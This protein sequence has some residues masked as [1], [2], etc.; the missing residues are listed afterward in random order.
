MGLSGLPATYNHETVSSEIEG[1]G[2]LDD[3]YGSVNRKN[4]FRDVA[5][6][7][8]EKLNEEQRAAFDQ[9]AS[10]IDSDEKEAKRLFFLEGAGG[11]GY[12]KNFNAFDKKNFFR[13]NIS[14]QHLN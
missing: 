7:H 14:L 12:F 3:F 9:I 4:S 8:L 6:A 1:E 10:A 13:Q 11:C 5:M 2:L